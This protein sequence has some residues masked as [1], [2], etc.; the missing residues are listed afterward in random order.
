LK[1]VLPGA[2]VFVAV[3]INKC[4]LPA[5]KTVAEISGILTSVFED[6]FAFSFKNVF[7]KLAFVSLFGFGKVV[8]A[9][10]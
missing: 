7:L 3:R 2:N 6:K 5:F 4:T 8:D 1:I 10:T 9:I